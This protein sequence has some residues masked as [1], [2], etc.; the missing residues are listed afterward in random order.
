MT[1]HH[2]QNMKREDQQDATI[3]CLLFCLNMLN[4]NWLWGAVLQDVI[5]MKVSV[6]LVEQKPS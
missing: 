6:Q 4:R 3:G 5:T 1:L 2:E